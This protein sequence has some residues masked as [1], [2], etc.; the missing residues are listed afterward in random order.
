[1]NKENELIENTPF[2]DGR[3]KKKRAT[4]GGNPVQLNQIAAICTEQYPTNLLPTT[5]FI[6]PRQAH[7]ILV[8]RVSISEGEL[9]KFV[10]LKKET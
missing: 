4:R 7:V 6:M 5:L 2:P 10:R 3:H 8:M 9:W 1:M